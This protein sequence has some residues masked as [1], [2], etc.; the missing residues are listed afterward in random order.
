MKTVLSFGGG[1]NSTALLLLKLNDIIDFDVMIFADTRGEHPETYRYIDTYIR[2]A[3]IANDIA[4][5]DVS[6]GNLYDDYYERNVIPVKMFR[7]CTDKYKVRPI[8]KFLKKTY[9]DYDTVVG[10]D[11]GEKHRAERFHGAFHFPLIDK[12]ITRQ[13]CKQIILDHGWPV[14]PKSGCYFCP[15]KQKKHWI[16]LLHEH[17]D[18]YLLA[19]AFEKNGRRYPKYGLANQRLETLRLAVDA[20]QSLT[21]WIDNPNEPTA[22]IMC[23]S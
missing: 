1:V 12:H 7:S 14:P 19:E 3:C 9:V 20:Q 15:Y 4:F 8:H 6:F 2:P 11:Y 23:H 10:I 16:Q 13:G 21:Q 5:H 18:L 22:C 17:R